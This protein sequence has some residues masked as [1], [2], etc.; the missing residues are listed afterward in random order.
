MCGIVGI[1]DSNNHIDYAEDILVKMNNAILHRGP[2]SQNIWVDKD[3]RIFFGHG[4]LS[5]IDLRAIANQPMVSSCKRYVLIFNGEIYNFNTI[6]SKIEKEVI[7]NWKTNSDTEVLVEA[8]S[9][10]GINH[11]LFS[12]LNGMFAFAV[13][14]KKEKKVF[15]ARDQIGEKPLYYGLIGGSLVFSSELISFKSIPHWKPKINYDALSC[16]LRHGYVGGQNS[17]FLGIKKLLPSHFIVCNERLEIKTQEY[18]KISDDN[19]FDKNANDDDIIEMGSKLIENSVALRM[20]SDVPLGTFLS[21]GI[22]SSIILSFMQSKSNFPVKTYTIGFEDQFYDESG[23]AKLI[24]NFFST[25]HNQFT[26]TENEVVDIIPDIPK[27]YNE[28]FADMSQIPAILLSRLVIKD[29][30]VVLTGDGGDELFYGYSRYN[31]VI[32]LWNIIKYIPQP[33]RYLFVNLVK[34]SSTNF[35]NN[36]FNFISNFINKFGKFYSI[37]DRIKKISYLLQ[38]D[39]FQHLYEMFISAWSISPLLIDTNPQARPYFLEKITES[40]TDKE[41]WMT[42]SD[43]KIYLPDDILVKLDRSTMSVG[44]EGRVPFLD[45]NII[46]FSSQIPFNYKYRE[47]ENKWILKKIL[48][49]KI[50]RHLWDNSKKGFSVPISSWLRGPL[51]DWANEL[52]SEKSLRQTEHLNINLIRLYWDEHIRGERNWQYPLWHILMFQSWKNHFF[53]N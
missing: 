20:N 27:I 30:K 21:G 1:F 50:P 53:Q 35:L 5:I 2:D 48:S 4:R 45:K 3:S 49:N 37:G 52:L 29:V 38:A 41:K 7:I 17:I 16:F 51:K 15:L 39:S 43:Q 13:W 42:D 40:F 11:K 36:N 12:L 9:L 28:P 24:S 8:I 44:L 33:I 23:Q 31:I 19:Y 18:N 47:N 22:D 10:W 26:L 32:K 34:I 25:D 6:K 46:N 14:D